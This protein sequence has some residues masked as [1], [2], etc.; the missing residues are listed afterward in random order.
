MEASELWAYVRLLLVF[1]VAFL[2]G[3]LALFGTLIED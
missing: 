2:A 1:D 3:G